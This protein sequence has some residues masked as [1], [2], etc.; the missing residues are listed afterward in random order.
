MVALRTTPPEI[1]P[2]SGYPEDPS[3]AGRHQAWL[4]PHTPWVLV[5]STL[6][7]ALIALLPL[8]FVVVRTASTGLVQAQTLLLRPRVG[9][10]LANTVQL[11]VTATVLAALIGLA[12]AWCTERT[13]LPGRHVWSVLAALPITVPAFVSS[14]C[15]VSL[16]TA[17]QGFAGAVLIVTLAYYPL[18]YLPVAALL[19]GMDPAL[20]EVARAQGCGPWRTFLRVTLPQARPALLGGSL[21]VAL[22]VLSEFGAFS[23][24]R[25]ATFTTEIYDEYQLS[26]DG[27][28][29]SLLAGVLAAVCVVLL[30]IELRIRGRAVAARVGKGAARRPPLY[31]L[32]RGTPFV[33]LA[34]VVFMAV[35]LGVP[36]GTLVYWLLNGSSAAFPLG[37]IVQ[38]MVSSLSLGVGAALLTT[39]CALPIAL[40]SV[41]FSSRLATLAERSTYVSQ[42]L[43]GIIIALALVVTSVHYF[44]SLYQTSALLLVAYAVMFLPL[45]LVAVRASVTQASSTVEDVA[46]SLGC[47]PF[48]ALRRVTIPLILPGLGAAAA[49]VF[50]S[51]VTELTAT[52]LLAPIGT[53]TLAMQVWTNTDSLAYA[54]AAPYAVLLI[55]V[56]AIPTYIL[57]R[58][59]GSLG[60]VGVS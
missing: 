14:Y 54:A 22:N 27:P 36:L 31:S 32:G 3:S 16:T 53:Q 45:A 19:R 37:T 35:A 57:T 8:G 5:V 47:T 1:A 59:L 6:L 12:L 25:F 26:F 11:T 44:R 20:E 40:L 58:Q 51:T 39:L 56:S 24:L 34:L 41:R 2:P 15:W 49:L 10:L 46:R 18:V 42:V 28:S 9:D 21:L 29:A 17:V 52:L 55:A 60:A 7:I 4:R 33:L 13:T 50:L 30:V 38:S 48:Q 23:L 43:P